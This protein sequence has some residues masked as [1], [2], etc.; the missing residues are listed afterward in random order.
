MDN[1]RN[2][3][4]LLWL[5]GSFLFSLLMFL[6]ILIGNPYVVYTDDNAMQ[7]APIIRPAFDSIFAGNGIPYWNFYQYKGFDIFSCGY[8]GLTNPFMYIS[9]MISRFLFHYSVDILAIYEWLLYWLGLFSMSLVLREMKLRRSTIIISLLAYSTPLIFFTYSF[10]YFEYNCYLMVPL[11]AWVML[12]THEKK[13]EWYAPGILL[14]FGLLLGHVQY[15]CYFVMVYCIIMVVWAVAEKK[16]ATLLRVGANLGIFLL[17]SACCLALSLRVSANREIILAKIEHQ[18]FYLFAIQINDYLN[19]FSTMFLSKKILVQYYYQSNIGLGIFAY[20]PVFFL[21]PFFNK[22]F[23]LNKS[24]YEKRHSGKSKLGKTASTSFI[25]I[26]ALVL[27]AH[28]IVSFIEY[29]YLIYMHSIITVLTI[30]PILGVCVILGYRLRCHN[31]DFSEKFTKVFFYML[32]IAL[33]LIIAPTILY[34]IAI[35]YYLAASLLIQKKEETP[36]IH[37]WLHAVLFAAFF[38]VIFA[39][40]EHDG[41]A[42]VLSK[43]PV[44]NGFRHLY[45]CAFIFIPLLVIAGAYVIESLKK[46]RKWVCILS[47]CFSALYL[48]N[49]VAIFHGHIHK[50]YQNMDYS[51]SDHIKIEAQVREQIRLHDLDANYRIVTV[52]DPE[53]YGPSDTGGVQY[54][55]KICVYALTK[56]YATPYGLFS[57]N[58]YDSV[59]SVKGFQATDHIMHEIFTEGMFDNLIGLPSWYDDKLNDKEFMEVFEK[60]WIESGIRYVLIPN[61]GPGANDF[62]K[63]FD[64]CDGLTVVNRSPWIYD[65]DL[66]EIDGVKPICSYNDYEKLPMTTRLDCLSFRT[67]F[68]ETTSVDIS[69][70]YE[71]GFRLTLKE[72]TTGKK[73]TVKLEENEMGYTKAAIPAG[74]YTAELAYTDTLMDVTFIVSI[75]TTLLTIATLVLINRKGKT[76]TKE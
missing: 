59:F 75:V 37:N 10:Y 35:L 27:C 17:L 49:I 31:L 46:S 39:V 73:S 18:E 62:L 34:V 65:F 68:Q 63:I 67:N 52:G 72:N 56:D 60:Q 23:N 50:N 1:K 9:Y 7:W 8:Y 30:P 58:G 51:T 54:S 74:D 29:E 21:I 5:G 38:F 26:L 24:F 57:I 36:A 47:L 13:A 15:A 25:I 66:V 70:T 64:Y 48:I 14:A 11:L 4:T 45:K 53:V 55:S 69:M 19:I 43:I 61:K 44:F 20:L 2:K 33:C 41:L 28:V 3:E 32:M 40:G 71:P 6:I 22:I 16:G 42:F 76:I 12:K